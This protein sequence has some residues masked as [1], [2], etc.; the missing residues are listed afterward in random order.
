[1]AHDVVLTNDKGESLC[2]SDG[3]IYVDKRLNINNIRLEV[4][5]YR[6]TF[7]KNFR[8]KYNYWTHFIYKGKLFKI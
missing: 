4:H 6:E 1:M 8:H 7:K 3:N 5:G 2:G